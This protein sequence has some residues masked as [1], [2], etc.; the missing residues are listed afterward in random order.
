MTPPIRLPIVGTCSLHALPVASELLQ[1][2]MCVLR[3]CL[4]QPALNLIRRKRRE[5]S[6]E[7]RARHR[8]R[9]ISSGQAAELL[10]LGREQFIQQASERGILY[11]Q[12]DG[13]E[14]Q[15]EL[16]ASKKL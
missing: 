3:D 4:K 5:R 2:Q 16:D 1:K 11:F 10:G 8:L 9:E 15:R 12:L 14:L 7:L 6:I 13:E